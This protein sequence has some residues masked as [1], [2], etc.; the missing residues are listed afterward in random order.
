M[1][2]RNFPIGL[3]FVYCNKIQFFKILLSLEDNQNVAFKRKLVNLWMLLKPHDNTIQEASA[4]KH[5][6]IQNNNVTNSH[7]L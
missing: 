6:T 3:L 1:W 2:D 5:L 4:S 7:G